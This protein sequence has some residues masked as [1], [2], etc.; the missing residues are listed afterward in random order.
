MTFTI[1]EERNEYSTCS[2]D[3][4]EDLG[5]TDHDP[6]ENDEARK[7]TQLQFR[8]L[9]S[10]VSDTENLREEIKHLKEEIASLKESP[11]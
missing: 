6:E 1:P 4:V 7:Y 8:V 10:L 3:L 2:R 5:W 9:K 11:K